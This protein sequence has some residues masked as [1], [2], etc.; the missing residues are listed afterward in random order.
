MDGTSFLPLLSGG[1]QS[2]R[3]EVVTAH[4]EAIH[5]YVN[6]EAR[7]AILDRMIAEGWQPNDQA[8]ALFKPYNIRCIQDED[9]AYMYNQWSDGKNKYLM[10]GGIS[11]HG[12]KNSRKPEIQDRVRMILYRVPEELYDL[13]A[14][15]HCLD[16]L[17]DDAS[18]RQ[19]RDEMRGRLA[20]WMEKTDDPAL[21]SFKK[22]MAQ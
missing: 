11:G 6:K 20:D 17:I 5:Y 16:N 1:T 19:V 15:P 10:G 22:R 7:K 2:G 3:T 9:Y 21:P 4:Y 13:R 8:R 18:H 12:M 14:D